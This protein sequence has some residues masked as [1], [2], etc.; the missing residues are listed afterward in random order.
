[1]PPGEEEGE[2]E[3]NGGREKREDEI[4]ERGEKWEIVGG[5]GERMVLAIPRG[6]KVRPVHL[7]QYNTNWE[8]SKVERVE[9][10][11]ARTFHQCL[12]TNRWEQTGNW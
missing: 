12:P 5:K 6:I 9:R 8:W 11:Q 4:G 2:R 7:A 1:M 10:L 3:E